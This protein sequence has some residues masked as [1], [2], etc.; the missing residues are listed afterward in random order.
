M[1]RPYLCV[2]D[3]PR[4]FIQFNPLGSHFLLLFKVLCTFKIQRRS[5]WPR[6]LR[7][8]SAAI[9]LLALRVRIPL[10]AWVSVSCECCVLSG[11]G[12]CVGLITRPEESYRMWCVWAWSSS[13]DNEEALAHWG[14]LGH[15]KTQNSVV[16][17]RAC[18][19]ISSN[20]SSLHCSCV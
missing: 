11:R 8:G 10:G 5:Q 14:L 7:R 17:F 12:L 18:Y 3:T 6:G 20:N 1:A 2:L 13:L 4:M 15:K 9:R 16:I 19:N